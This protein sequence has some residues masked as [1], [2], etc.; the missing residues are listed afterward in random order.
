VSLPPSGPGN[1]A[2]LCTT[3][4]HSFFLLGLLFDPENRGDM[5]LR[6]MLHDVISQ[7]VEIFITADI[8]PE[9]LQIMLYMETLQ[10]LQIQGNSLQMKSDKNSVA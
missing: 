2:L 10:K 8:K 7:T 6:N 3:C 5:F 1:D 9:I 4:F